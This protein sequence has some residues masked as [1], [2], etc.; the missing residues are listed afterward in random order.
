MYK[1]QLVGLEWHAGL[2]R[3]T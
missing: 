1:I 3:A 2:Y